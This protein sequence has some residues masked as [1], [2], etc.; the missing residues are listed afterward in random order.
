MKMIVLFFSILTVLTASAAI[1]DQ[2]KA[3]L[4]SE[5]NLLPN[6]GFEG[7]TGGWTAS[8]GTFSATSTNPFT[9]KL[10][11]TWDPSAGSETLSSEAITVEQGFLGRT[12]QAEM[13]YTYS[14]SSGDI[15][16]EALD[17]GSAVATLDIDPASTA[18]K[19]QLVFDCPDTN[20]DTLQ[21]RLRSTVDAGQIKFDDSFLGRDRNTF[22]LSQALRLPMLDVLATLLSVLLLMFQPQVTTMFA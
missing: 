5:V 6:P 9:G 2:D 20:T 19:A 4:L 15:V 22:Q 18:R 1:N 21:F 7:S 3:K 11:A 12:C 13:L 17:T 10:S 14:G 16:L 8:G